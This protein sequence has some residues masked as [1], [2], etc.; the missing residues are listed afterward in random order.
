MLSAWKAQGTLEANVITIHIAEIR[1]ETRTR[2]AMLHLAKRL[3]R[4]RLTQRSVPTADLI[5][6]RMTTFIIV[7][8]KSY[9]DNL[10]LAI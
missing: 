3:V 7:F 10:L 5:C 1:C 4:L 2:S 8:S 6:H 9:I